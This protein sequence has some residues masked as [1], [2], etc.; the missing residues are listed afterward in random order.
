VE[1]FIK[2]AFYQSSQG[3]STSPFSSRNNMII[4]HSLNVKEQINYSS[5]L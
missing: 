5:S 3:I 1:P 4:L 2:I